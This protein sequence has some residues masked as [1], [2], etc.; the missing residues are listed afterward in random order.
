M[1]KNVRGTVTSL[2][3]YKPK[4]CKAAMVCAAG[5]SLDL[6]LSL[7][8]RYRKDLWVLAVDRAL[9]PLLTHGI[10]PDLVLTLDPKKKLHI[11]SIPIP[12]AAPV[13]F[14]TLQLKRWNGPLYLYN[15]AD[16]DSVALTA[17]TETFKGLMGVYSKHNVGEMAVALSTIWANRIAYTGLDFAIYPNRLYALGTPLAKLEG[18]PK[19]NNLFLLYQSAFV[20]N[21]E[22]IYRHK[23][24][25]FNLSKGCLPFPYQL[26]QFK[27]YLD[28]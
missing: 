22:R 26:K 16:P 5:A 7:I 10:V 6:H 23:A 4:A 3:N 21:Y 13:T 27:E 17:I 24:V 25:L 15:S 1:G 11:P 12:L 9:L 18:I 20:D 28:G 14:D 8:D 2:H 19:V